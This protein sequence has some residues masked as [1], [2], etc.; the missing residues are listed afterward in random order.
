MMLVVLRLLLRNRKAAFCLLEGRRLYRL[1]FGF[2][3]GFLGLHMDWLFVAVVLFAFL[4]FLLSTIAG[5][6]GSLV[7]VSILA[8][9]YDADVA[10]ALA[11]PVMLANSLGKLAVFYRHVRLK[12]A[13][14]L[15]IGILPGIW[16]GVLLLVNLPELYIR[17]GIGAFLLLALGAHLFL[18]R[19]PSRRIGSGGLAIVG[20]CYGFSSGFASAGGPAKAI[21]LSMGGY[22]K[23]AFV[24]TAA[25]LSAFSASLRIPLYRANGML[26]ADSS[27]V[28]VL[29][30]LI[31]PIA[32]FWGRHLLNRLDERRFRTLLAFVI[33][34]ACIKIMLT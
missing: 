18:H 33:V 32:I 17:K 10:V 5:F 16:F 4:G 24:A 14:I 25:L 23:E 7:I 2:P 12:H 6:G 1:L 11:S 13:L 27:A 21:G 31:A 15:I 19:A 8:V 22:T 3:G 26:S 34:I 9:Y 28:I 30:I 29:L 20:F